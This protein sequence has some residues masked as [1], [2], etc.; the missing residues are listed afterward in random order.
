M[1]PADEATFLGALRALHASGGDAST[2]V[3]DSAL[4]DE[5]ALRD[6]LAR[7]LRRCRVRALHTPGS[8]TLPYGAA[9]LLGTLDHALAPSGPV[10]LDVD[11][12]LEPPAGL[13][14]VPPPY[15]LPVQAF[16]FAILARLLGLTPASPIA[17]AAAEANISVVASH[18]R[19]LAEL[20]AL[21]TGGAGDVGL[22]SDAL[23]ALA[24][25]TARVDPTG[26]VYA[27]SVAHAFARL[28]PS[29]AVLSDAPYAAISPVVSVAAA[30]RDVFAATAAGVFPALGAALAAA[31]SGR[32]DGGAD[33][34]H[35]VALH[36]CAALAAISSI[37]AARAIVAAAATP[38]L[39]LVLRD[40]MRDM[41]RN[42]WPEHS[43]GLVAWRVYIDAAPGTP[44][45]AAARAGPF[46]PMFDPVA[47]LKGTTGERYHEYVAA[48][49]PVRE[50]ELR[51]R[52]A[53]AL[54]A[55]TADGAEAAAGAGGGGVGLPQSASSASPQLQQPQ[56]QHMQQARAA[57]D[58]HWRWHSDA[59]LAGDDEARAAAVQRRDAAVA[60][61][62]SLAATRR[63]DILVRIAATPDLV[64]RLLDA[65]RTTVGL[66]TVPRMA[67]SALLQLAS[68][69]ACASLLLPHRDAI[70][71]VYAAA[72]RSA[73]DA[74]AASSEKLQQV[75]GSRSVP[76]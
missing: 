16:V 49:P 12:A 60:V 25:V 64:L 30:A 13:A 9:V 26:T 62:A 27:R 54:S 39:L 70:A 31:G 51:L 61:V 33:C 75:Q 71:V 18:P 50:R 40:M 21:A 3:A 45:Y 8:C 19:L 59:L 68:T 76:A 52:A 42:L 15:A 43:S 73:P 66:S 46:P 36:I 24:V 44:E 35:P 58:Q 1:A 29:L 34:P 38:D 63:G 41:P 14:A 48:L 74:A 53:A 72:A 5:P 69:G 17:P 22:R 57:R 4:A 6:A 67:V 65:T 11:V 23:A 28:P 10:D 55:A 47:D 56:L 20:L 37:R 32:S 2:H 7:L